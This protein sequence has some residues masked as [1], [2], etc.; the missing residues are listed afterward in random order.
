MNSILFRE[1]IPKK[2]KM[3]QNNILVGHLPT[4]KTH[5]TIREDLV[6]TPSYVPPQSIKL[7]FSTE[8]MK[9]KE[10][11]SKMDPHKWRKLRANAYD[12]ERLKGALTQKQRSTLIINNRCDI[13]E[14]DIGVTRATMKMKELIH[15][16]NLIPSKP[17][18]IYV[19]I[20]EGPGGFM[21]AILQHMKY[22]FTEQHIPI[23]YTMH[24]NTLRT[25][26]AN[27]DFTDEKEE[28]K[29]GSGFNF[30]RELQLKNHGQHVC[31][32]IHIHYGLDGKGDICDTDTIVDLVENV[33][34]TND[35][36]AILVTADGGFN[37]SS[38]DTRIKEIFHFRLLLAEIVT[39]IQVQKEGGAFVIKFFDC[40]YMQTATLVHLICSMY[41]DIN[42]A[43]PL[44][45]RPANSE[46]YIVARRF[47]K[48]GGFD[49]KEQFSAYVEELMTILDTF[50]ENNVKYYFDHGVFENLPPKDLIQALFKINMNLNERQ[51]NAMITTLNW[52]QE[53]IT[54]HRIEEQKS[55]SKKLL[56]TVCHTKADIPIY[57]K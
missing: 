19:H 15:Y 18:N 51:I 11:I 33:T 37:V 39:A 54:Q 55:Y 34:E 41:E 16:F 40:N 17:D 57:G 2:R 20:A 31:K 53:R 48:W 12:Y 43:K 6:T 23:R 9:Y 32:N 3:L 45:S 21:E 46:R 14:D 49:T 47:K 27:T 38:D 30:I 1:S 56:S 4:Q 13:H 25:Y 42:V 29:E 7:G 5:P 22:T 35:D 26:H 24:A 28:K 52:P 10:K 50:E 36:L 44:T 8:V